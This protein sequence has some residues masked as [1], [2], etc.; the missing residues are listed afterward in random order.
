MPSAASALPALNPNQPTQSSAAPVTVKG[1]LCGAIYSVGKPRRF[2][3]TRAHTSAEAPELICTTVPPAKSR[4]PMVCSQPPPHTQCARGSYTHVAHN[5]PKTR[6]VV[7]LLTYEG[8]AKDMPGAPRGRP[9]TALP[10]KT[11]D[12]HRMRPGKFP[13]VTGDTTCRGH[14]AVCAQGANCAAPA[15]RRRMVLR[16]SPRCASQWV[17]ILMPS[18]A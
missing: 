5:R 1:R 10:L 11:R 12:E 18:S 17:T 15:R 8:S 13:S 16:R 14:A 3:T 2:P 6:K 4:A 7:N 9:H